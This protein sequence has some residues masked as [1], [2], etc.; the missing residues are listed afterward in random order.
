MYE[1]RTYRERQVSSHIDFF[2]AGLMETDL[3]IG[4][5]KCSFREDMIDF[6]HKEVA[7]LRSI[8]L[9]YGREHGTFFSSLAPLPYDSKAPLP[10]QEMLAAGIKTATG[11]MSSVA[12]LFARHVG[13]SLKHKY[14]LRN[15]LIE[16]GGDNY[17]LIEDFDV[18]M[19]IISGNSDLSGRL[20]IKIRREEARLGVCTSSGRLGHSFS[21]GKAH[22][23]TVL[24]SDIALADA[25]ATKLCNMVQTRPDIET[26][27]EFA[28]D[29]KG[30]RSCIIIMDDTVGIIGDCEILSL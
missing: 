3:W 18:D 13:D 30:L 2:T 7:G 24:S 23:V 6:V 1:P 27:L 26:T 22:S 5:D 15:V 14:Q 11:P 10:V 28:K 12:G 8:L 29:I 25:C 20:G 4:V 21:L 9:E 16:N 19:P 17:L